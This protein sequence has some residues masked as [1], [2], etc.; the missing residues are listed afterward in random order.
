MKEDGAKEAIRLSTKIIHSGE[1]HMGPQGELTTPIA[2]SAVFCY[3]NQAQVM[4][5][6]RDEEK[7]FEYARY[8]TPTHV[9]VERKM[10]ALEGAEDSLLFAT[11]MSAVTTTLF[12]LLSKGDHLVVVEDA[13]KRTRGFCTE[14]L[15]R[16]GVECTL[17]PPG[18]TGDMLAAIRPNTKVFFAESPTNPYLAVLD[19]PP[20]IEGCHKRGVLLIIDSTLATPINQRPIEFGADLVL[21]SMTKYLAGHNDVLGGIVS[22]RADILKRLREFQGELGGTAD[23]HQAYLILRGMKTLQLRVEKMNASGMAVAKFLE[24]HKKVARVFYPGL[25]SSPYHTIA[26]KQMSG[27]GSLISFW[28][29][30]GEAEAFRVMDALRIPRNAPSLGGVE[31]LVCHPASLTYYKS[32]RALREKFDI[33]DELIRYAVGIEDV[34]D[35]IADLDQA[36][37]QI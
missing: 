10:A 9:A 31:S 6:V 14:T 16:F 21:H 7:R 15:P 1:A 18:N 26:A 23:P 5:Y 27:Y 2:Q 25:K 34:E 28:I 8:G 17:V 33:R 13:Y 29:K 12:C 3:E 11:G 35:I 32:G 30:G 37:A 19:L 4:R 20:L 22:G 24:K 36:L